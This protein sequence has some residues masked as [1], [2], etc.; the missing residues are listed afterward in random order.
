M[1][2]IQQ[3][4]IDA[5]ATTQQIVPVNEIIVSTWSAKHALTRAEDSTMC[6]LLFE[7]DDLPHF[8]TW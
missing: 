4:D 2:P 3:Y 6:I 8:T 5:T 7:N 1:Q